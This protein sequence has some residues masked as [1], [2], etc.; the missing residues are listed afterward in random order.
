MKKIFNMSENI[1]ILTYSS[2]YPN[3]TN[4]RHGIFVEQR[5]RH[6][7]N[8]G[9]I[10]SIVVS[11]VPWFPLAAL[12]SSRYAEYKKI[13][14]QDTR[15][16]IDIL[17]PRFPNIP[18]IGMSI[19]PFIMALFT[20]RQ[21]S[22]LLKSGYNFDVID[23]HYFYPDG[24]ASVIIGK[25]TKK[26]VVITARGSDINLIS[27][28]LIPGNLIRWAAGKTK[29]IISVSQALKNSIERLG[30]NGDKVKVLRNGV[31]TE[32]FSFLQDREKIRERLGISGSVMLSVGNLVPLK[33]HDLAIKTL[34]ILTEFSLYIIGDG[35]ELNN[36]KKLSRML[37][38]EKR[39]HFKKPVSQEALRDYYGAAD[40]LVL[41]SSREG[42]ANV[43]LESMACGTPVVATNVGGNSEI[44]RSKTAGV[45][46][47]QRTPEDIIA[48]I[49]EVMSNKCS[50]EETRVYAEDFSWDETTA[51][52]IEI[53]SY[54]KQESS[55]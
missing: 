2:L 48:G 33:G 53:F 52:Q 5:L 54:I 15:Y 50:R 3:K 4:P 10:R 24:V 32:L 37:D 16:G 6:L 45:I 21:I 42:W 40:V 1:N 28:Y 12:F 26:P 34:T 49:N 23:A 38:V 46:I 8:S 22:G 11:P 31:D 35:P 7:V 55:R 44:V 30:V 36:L 18:F 13:P 43:L 29:K 47:S 51:G 39:V 19:A 14:E 9:K 20:Y 41:A 25:L 27:R 17:Y